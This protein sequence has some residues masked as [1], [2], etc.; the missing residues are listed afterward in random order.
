VNT[1]RTTLYTAKSAHRTL[2]RS[3][4]YGSSRR[5]RQLASS[6]FFEVGDSA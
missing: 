3:S 4:L 5:P 1:F 2:A 6:R